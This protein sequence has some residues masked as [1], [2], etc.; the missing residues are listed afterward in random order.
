MMFSFRE[1][2]KRPKQTP[3]PTP[4]QEDT[5]TNRPIHECQERTNEPHNGESAQSSK[6]LTLFFKLYAFILLTSTLVPGINRILL[7]CKFGFI[8]FL[9]KKFTTTNARK[10]FLE[11]PLLQD[12]FSNKS[13]PVYSWS[14]KF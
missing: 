12:N 9:K 14:C 5:K 2:A 8:L 10:F 7:S 3:T 11:K 1:A 4:P 13:H 6:A